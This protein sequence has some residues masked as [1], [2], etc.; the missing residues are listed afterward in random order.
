M[1]PDVQLAGSLA[2]LLLS[3]PPLVA[4]GHRRHGADHLGKRRF[5][6]APA[7]GCGENRGMFTPS[8]SGDSKSERPMRS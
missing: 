6:R 2:A 8:F 4:D 7:L 5:I 3:F 1:A